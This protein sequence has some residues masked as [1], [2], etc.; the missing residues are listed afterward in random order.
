MRP[1]T[2][3]STAEAGDRPVNEARKRQHLDTQRLCLDAGVQFV[4]LVA[5][6]C[7][8]AATRVWSMLGAAVGSLSG[9]PGSVGTECLQ[10]SLSVCQQRENARALLR[11]Q[12]AEEAAAVPLP[13]P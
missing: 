8:P 13:A 5:E 4:P 6:A 1:G 10:Q 11:R 3:V 12:P 9:D 7:G 2:L